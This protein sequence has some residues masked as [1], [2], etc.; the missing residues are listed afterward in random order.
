MYRIDN[1]INDESD[2][3][4]ES[5]HREY[6]NIFNFSSLSGTRYIELR[7]RLRNAMKGLI[8]INNS[9]NKFFFWCHIRQL[10]PLKTDPEKVAKALKLMVNNLDFEGVD[11]PASKIDFGKFKKSTCIN[12]FC[13]KIT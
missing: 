12:G 10:N 3:V 13:L 4:I 11:F 1:W 7:C 6:V 8:N 2:W 5:V 9:G